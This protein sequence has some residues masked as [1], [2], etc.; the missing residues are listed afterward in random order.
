[1]TEPDILNLKGAEVF[2]KKLIHSGLEI[3][4]RKKHHSPSLERC[5]WETESMEESQVSLRQGEIR[6]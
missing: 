3:V 6:D 1:M 2:Y 4:I 5:A